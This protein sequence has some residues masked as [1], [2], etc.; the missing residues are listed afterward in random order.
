M[1]Y[2]AVNRI[3]VNSP[4]EADKIVEGFRGRARLVDRQPGFISFE[5]WREEKGG[6]VLVATRWRTKEDFESWVNGS[7]FKEAHKRAS[8]SPGSANGSSYTVEIF[9]QA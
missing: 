4:E 2:V 3:T 1:A 7:A 8:N 9:D 5:L 6:E